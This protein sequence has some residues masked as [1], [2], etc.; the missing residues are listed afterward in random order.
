MSDKVLSHKGYLGSIETSLDDNCLFGEILY[1]NDLVTY[2]GKT[3]EELHKAFV[4]A[5]EHYL[6]RCAEEGVEP[7]KPCSGTFNVRMAPELHRTACLQAT[8]KGVSLNEFVKE[9]VSMA[10]CEEKTVV[11]ETHLHTHIQTVEIHGE[12][13]PYEDVM[14]TWQKASESILSKNH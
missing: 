4:E 13:S 10:V 11:N 3:V 2:E 14:S 5:V 8:R 7:D 9:A 6:A 1:V 12:Q